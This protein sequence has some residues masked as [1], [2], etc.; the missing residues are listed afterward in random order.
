[1]DNLLK[2]RKMKAAHEAA[3]LFCL[4]L[5]FPLK[6]SIF[7]ARIESNRNTNLKIE[8]YGLIAFEYEKF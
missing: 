2:M 1:M 8:M 7:A 6:V 3:P 5:N 4:F